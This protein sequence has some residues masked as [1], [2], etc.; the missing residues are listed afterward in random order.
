MLGIL[1]NSR[2]SY[3]VRYLAAISVGKLGGI[4]NARQALMDALGG[5]GGHNFVITQGA[6]LGGLGGELGGLADS[7]EII[8]SYAR[9]GDKPTPVRVAAIQ[10]LAK[11][12]GNRRVI[13]ELIALS[14]DDNFRVRSAVV[15]AAGGS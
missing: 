6:L 13:D 9:G 3:Y 15:A 2:E 14:K 4:E 10:S 11:F 5:Y 8:S 1:V 7:V 12:P